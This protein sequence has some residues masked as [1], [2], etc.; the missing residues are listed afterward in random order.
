MRPT[1]EEN[2][3]EAETGWQ[4]RALRLTCDTAGLVVVA[5]GTCSAVWFLVYFGVLNSPWITAAIALPVLLGATLYVWYVTQAGRKTDAENWLY[6][7]IF[8]PLF[9]AMSFAIDVFIGSSNGH[10]SNFVQAGFHAGG[11]FGIVLTVCICPIGTVICAG[12]WARSSLLDRWFP[13][14]E[15][16]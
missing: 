6:G 10:Y 15:A 2:V 16:D 12:S 11:P 7:T 8:T 14:P 9:G 5:A 13:K 4:M 1:A 3:Q